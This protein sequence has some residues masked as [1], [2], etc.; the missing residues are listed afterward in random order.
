MRVI[1]SIVVAL[2]LVGAPAWAQAPAPAACATPTYR[3]FDFW[4]GSWDVYSP[5][6]KK[7]GTNTIERILGGCA[8]LENWTAADGG[9]GKSLNGFDRKDDRWHQSW[10]DARGGR[11]E[12]AGKGGDGR[13]QLEAPG[14]RITWTLEP[15]GSVRQRWERWDAA[16]N[17]WTVAF[18]GKYV[19]R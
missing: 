13:M 9:T 8:L 2:S 12:L 19:K 4:L 6:G 11:L 3:Q 10:I 16:T 14:Q 5:D 1:R 15:D 7:A 17:A 18:D